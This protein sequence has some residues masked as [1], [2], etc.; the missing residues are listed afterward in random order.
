[1]DHFKKKLGPVLF[2]K[3]RME[4]GK[5]VWVKLVR[6]RKASS[7]DTTFAFYFSDKTLVEEGGK[8]VT[9]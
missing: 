4:E 8:L 9:I 3:E 2:R 5:G 1:M 6:Y 7:H